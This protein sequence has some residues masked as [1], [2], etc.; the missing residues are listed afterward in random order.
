MVIPTRDRREGVVATVRHVLGQRD[1]QLEVVVVDDGSRDGTS[2][3]LA[4]LGCAA[5]RVVRHAESL[6]LARAR[7]AGLSAASAPWVALLD[8]D[9]RGRLTSCARNSR[10]LRRRPPTSSIPRRSRWSPVGS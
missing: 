10:P 6:G 7:N 3:A 2:E 5:V 4:A 9:D 8:D 1:V